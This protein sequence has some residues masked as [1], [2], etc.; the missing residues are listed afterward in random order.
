MAS[1]TA[2][3]RSAGGGLGQAAMFLIAFGGGV[4][5]GHGLDR[6]ADAPM[7][8]VVK[9]DAV[10]ASSPAVET[11]VLPP[12][13]DPIA[14]PAKIEEVTEAQRLFDAEV[15]RLH[16]ERGRAIEE[17]RRTFGYVPEGEGGD[18]VGTVRY[19][20]IA[21]PAVVVDTGLISIDGQDIRIAGIIP[22][23]PSAICEGPDGSSFD[24]YNWAL[25]GV[26]SWV[27][28]REATCSLMIRNE[29]VSG[30]CEI[31]SADATSVVDIGSWM[32]SA[33]LAVADPYA[34]GLY[35]QAQQTAK[36]NKVGV[37]SGSFAFNGVTN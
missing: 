7:P 29:T 28:G 13:V 26:Q 6:A 34:S 36:D 10:P 24:C 2:V 8:V 32:V 21:G 33:G 18:A 23:P 11:D 1:K 9:E 31:P 30:A 14:P 25:E 12:P 37:W 17:A 4:Y 22:I 16:E 5:V 15:Q 19:G 35:D 20:S 27:G 3:L